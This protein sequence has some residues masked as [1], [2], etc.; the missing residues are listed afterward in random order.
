MKKNNPRK[1]AAVEHLVIHTGA[2]PR[3]DDPFLKKIA[4]MSLDEIGVILEIIIEDTSKMFLGLSEMKQLLLRTGNSAFRFDEIELFPMA[5]SRG[6]EEVHLRFEFYVHGHVLRNRHEKLQIFG[7]AVAIF[8]PGSM[9]DF[10]VYSAV[11][12]PAENR[13]VAAPDPQTSRS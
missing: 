6:I 7:Q 9:A 1:P 12:K 13:A 4:A 5:K 8:Q 10:D 11:L 3:L 2:L